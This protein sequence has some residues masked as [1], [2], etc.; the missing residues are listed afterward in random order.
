M[1]I[2]VVGGPDRAGGCMRLLARSRGHQLEHHDGD[3]SV[4]R[5][6]SL[7]AMIGRADLVVIVTGINSHNAVLS[8]RALVRRLGVPSLLCK[9]FGIAQLSR[10]IEAIDRQDEQTHERNVARGWDRALEGR[11]LADPGGAR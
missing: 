3:W 4:R 10:L 8:A 1:I 5:K 9:R 2:A 11:V 6:A 7:E